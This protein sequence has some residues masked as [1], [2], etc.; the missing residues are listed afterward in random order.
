[1]C[2]LL[3]G[4]QWCGTVARESIHVTPASGQSPC[5]PRMADEVSIS[6]T[7]IPSCLA[8]PVPLERK[9]TE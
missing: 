1:M 3:V 6:L 4:E 2:D 9:G 5:F 8:S 7:C